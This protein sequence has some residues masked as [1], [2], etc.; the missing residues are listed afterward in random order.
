MQEMQNTQVLSLGQ[1]NP[2]EE[3]MTIHSSILDW[4]IPWTGEPGGLQ[5]MGCKE[6]DTTGHACTHK[7]G[8]LVFDDH[9]AL[10][11]PSTTCLRNPYL[12]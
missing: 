12:F 9:G 11:H 10:C 2:L 3:E 8:S 5:S 1:E 6:S 4:E 7:Y